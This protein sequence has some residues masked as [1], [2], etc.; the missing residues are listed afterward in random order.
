[1]FS[2]HQLHFPPESSEAGKS[3]GVG[4]KWEAGLR[5]KAQL[6][7]RVKIQNVKL[8]RGA[9]LKISHGKINRNKAIS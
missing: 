8:Y 5:G 9:G 7:N 1:M 4:E 2:I 3:E 6:K